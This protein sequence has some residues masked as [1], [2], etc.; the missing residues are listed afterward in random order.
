MHIYISLSLSLPP[1]SSKSK[2][3][4]HHIL[5]QQFCNSAAVVYI[6][7]YICCYRTQNQ[8]TEEP[9]PTFFSVLISE[10]RFAAGAPKAGQYLTKTKN[11]NNT[12]AAAVHTGPY[13]YSVY[14]LASTPIDG[15][16]GGGTGD[17]GSESDMAGA[18]RQASR[19]ELSSCGHSGLSPGYV[20]L[21][22]NVI[23]DYALESLLSYVLECL[24]LLLLYCI[25]YT[26]TLQHYY[27]CSAYIQQ[28]Q[29]L[30]HLTALRCS[31]FLSK[32]DASSC[33]VVY[34]QPISIQCILSKLL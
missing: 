16:V 21:E 29:R 15:G 4:P 2:S 8:T 34:P 7:W 17:R 30:L 33:C 22:W 18:A 26:C 27:V 14:A 23:E 19:M 32:Q 12:G 5:S 20:P 1:T 24:L 25:I 3:S 13:Q 6:T 10:A 11:S 9:E 28:R 31:V